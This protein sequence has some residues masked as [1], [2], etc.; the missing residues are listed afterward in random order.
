MLFL[1]ELVFWSKKPQLQVLYV[2][3]ECQ[4]GLVLLLYVLMRLSL[5]YTVLTELLL[6]RCL[7]G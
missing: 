5:L 6:S 7:L 1:I 2:L 4:D 3:P